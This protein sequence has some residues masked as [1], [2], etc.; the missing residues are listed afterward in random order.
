MKVTHILVL[1]VAFQLPFAG[2]AAAAGVTISVYPSS[3]PN[4]GGSANW[5]GYV[6][7]ALNSL[8]NGLGS[9]GDWTVSPTAYEVAGSVIAPGDI[10]VTSFNS[11]HGQVNP[12]APFA[13]EY[14]NR[15]HFGLHAFGD[16]TSQFSLSELTFDMH[17]SDS[18][19][20]LQYSGDFVGY[21][22]NGVTRYGIDWGADRVKGGGDDIVYTL[23]NG[24]TL[25]DELVYVGVGNAWW[26]GGADPDPAN[27]VGGPQA[28][29]DDLFYWI[30]ADGP[31]TVSCSYDIGNY[32]GSASVDVVA[33]PVPGALLLGGLG[34]GLIG[35]LRSRRGL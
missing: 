9:T 21:S 32:S 29:M 27:P 18:W 5:G 2:L 35:W 17:S 6:V 10:A 31:I 24:T 15:L 25:V 12:P 20:S 7:N 11:W 3:A 26:P 4:A 13:N 16:G 28:A 23:G 33:V 1:A 34:V 22:Y 19:D 8:E 30:L 14:G